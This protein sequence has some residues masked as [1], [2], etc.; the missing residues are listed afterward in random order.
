MLDTTAIA[1]AQ[2]TIER[3]DRARLRAES[4][5]SSVTVSTKSA[6]VR[7][8]S[9]QHEHELDDGQPMDVDAGDLRDLA[10]EEHQPEL[11]RA[12]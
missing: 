10:V 3:N 1:I 5:G 12:R 2:A 11:R 7:P 4:A 8:Q 6:P 9:R